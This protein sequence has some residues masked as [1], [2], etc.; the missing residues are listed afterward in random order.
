MNKCGTALR[1]SLRVDK[2]RFP[3][4]EKLKSG[5]AIKKPQSQKNQLMYQLDLQKVVYERLKQQTGLNFRALKSVLKKAQC[6]KL[7]KN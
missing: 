7:L 2:D 6:S 1:R 4:L 3:F 5:R